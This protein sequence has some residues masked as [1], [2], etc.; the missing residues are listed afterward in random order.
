M[1]DRT[2]LEQVAEI[3]ESRGWQRAEGTDGFGWIDPDREF[4]G[5]LHWTHALEAAVDRERKSDARHFAT[6]LAGAAH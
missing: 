3:L 1:E 4:L 2:V 6:A 5:R